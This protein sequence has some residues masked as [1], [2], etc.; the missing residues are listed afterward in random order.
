VIIKLTVENSFANWYDL[1]PEKIKKANKNFACLENEQNILLYN[2]LQSNINK[3]II[4]GF[5]A[6]LKMTGNNF[7]CLPSRRARRGEIS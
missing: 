5:F 1:L 7:F 2:G 3:G 6:S 4:K